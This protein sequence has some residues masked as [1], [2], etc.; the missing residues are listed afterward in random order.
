MK[1]QTVWF[2][3]SITFG[4]LALCG[5]GYILYHKG[6]ANPGFAVVPMTMQLACLAMY[7]T[8]KSKNK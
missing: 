4:I 1:K 2:I 5:A 6:E 8:D 3:L 7:R